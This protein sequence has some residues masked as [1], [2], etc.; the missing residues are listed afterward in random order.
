[1]LLDTGRNGDVI[2]S[3]EEDEKEKVSLGVISWQ[4]AV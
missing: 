1:M 4:V 2:R 3:E